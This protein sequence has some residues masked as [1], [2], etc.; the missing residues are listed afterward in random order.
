MDQIGIE[1]HIDARLLDLL[2]RQVGIPCQHQNCTIFPVSF[3]HQGQRG[4]HIGG[5]PAVDPGAES[6]I[7]QVCEMTVLVIEILVTDQL[8]PLAA[9]FL[10]WQC[11]GVIVIFLVRFLLVTTLGQVL[12]PPIVFFEHLS[13]LCQLTHP[14][15]APTRCGGE[16]ECHSCLPRHLMR[17]EPNRMDDPADAADH[18]VVALHDM[19]A[20]DSIA[21]RI[22]EEEA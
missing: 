14:A 11:I 8:L 5:R 3:G 6:T 10:R 9:T 2:D 12:S 20:G 16:F 18:A 19:N 4:S 22:L 1:N 7:D 17:C 21:Q 13:K 15:V